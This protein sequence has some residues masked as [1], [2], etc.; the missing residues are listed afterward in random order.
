MSFGGDAD[1]AASIEMFRAVREAGINFFDTAD[2]YNG[3]ASETI[4]GRLAR[5]EGESLVMATRCSNATGPAI[6]PRGNSSRH[7]TRA[8]EA[9]LKRLQTDR[10]D[11]LSLHQHDPAVPVEE[12]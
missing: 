10:L 4:L 7:V 5:G 6:K 11:I 1:E 3:G 12:S 9:S 2:Q 8:V